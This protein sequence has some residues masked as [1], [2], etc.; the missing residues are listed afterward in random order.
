MS[1]TGT[2]EPTTNICTAVTQIQ[3]NIRLHS[4]DAISRVMIPLSTIKV[5]NYSKLLNFKLLNFNNEVQTRAVALHIVREE[6]YRP[7]NV[8]SHI[9]TD[10]QKVSISQCTA[11]KGED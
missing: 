2:A 1:S 7:S 11:V 4:T 9:V 6:K 8:D 5:F 3:V 10:H